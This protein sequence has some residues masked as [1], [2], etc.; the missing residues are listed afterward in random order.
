MAH[1]DWTSG[2]FIYLQQRFIY[3]LREELNFCC[4]EFCIWLTL[5]DRTRLAAINQSLPDVNCAKQI[6]ICFKSIETY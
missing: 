1:R 5:I 3:V 6:F 4:K 2:T